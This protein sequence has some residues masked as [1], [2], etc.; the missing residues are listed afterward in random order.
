MVFCIPEHITYLLFMVIV[1]AY[2][3]DTSHSHIH[4]DSTDIQYYP[5]VDSSHI[6][7]YVCKVFKRGNPLESRRLGTSLLGTAV[8]Q[9]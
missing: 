6:H 2:A 9:P 3:Q 7:V 5:S 4:A 1:S 8:V